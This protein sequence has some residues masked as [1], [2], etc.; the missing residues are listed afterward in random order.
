[1][2]DKALRVLKG[3]S[4][5]YDPMHALIFCSSHGYTARLVLLWEKIGTYEDVWMDRNNEGNTP[6]ASSQ[7][8]CHFNL[9]GP[10]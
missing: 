4:I 8:A 5:L 1:M 2:R 9:Y 6:E 3:E 7:V 10:T